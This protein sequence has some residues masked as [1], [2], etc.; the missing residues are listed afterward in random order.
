MVR[1]SRSPDWQ[2]ATPATTTPARVA[3]ATTI[4]REL[5]IGAV[6]PFDPQP[7]RELAV[8]TLVLVGELSNPGQ[9]GV[10]ASVIAALP[11]A[12]SATLPGQEHM[13][14]MTAPELVARELLAWAVPSGQPG[15]R[16]AHMAA[17]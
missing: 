3:A 13:A 8:P 17:D 10:C 9:R 11:D 2:G 14:Q 1:L 4:P 16:P 7:Y 5:R 6:A 15:Q 12:R